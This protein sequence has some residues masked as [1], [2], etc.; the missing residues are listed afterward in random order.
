MTQP[1]CRT[2]YGSYLQTALLMKLS[3]WACMPLT[4]LNEKFNIQ[5]GVYPAA[6]VLPSLG[7]WT[8]GNG[9]HTFSVDANGI[10]IP[11]PIQ[12][13]ATD[14]ALYNHLPFVLRPIANDI[15]TAQQALYGLR[16]IEQYNGAAYVAYYL[17][18]MVLTDVIA[19]MELIN[20][21]SGVTTVTP[22]VANNSNLNPTPPVLSSSGVN[23]TTGNYAAASAQLSLLLGAADITELINVANVKY[24]D[25]NAAI[26]SEVG[27]CSGIDA[28]VSSPAVNN[29]Q[30]SFNEAIAVQIVSFINT[31]YPVQY[32]NN[33]I[34]LL[35]DVGATEPLL[36]L[37]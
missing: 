37:S 9:G 29:T 36:T 26:I 4:T 24:N 11:T 34:T 28:V 7:Y 18:R 10:A 2:L 14:A 32:S 31:F 3:N 33:A 17:R 16:R 25:P 12:H 27:L 5:S 23:L 6:G 20:V 13:I 1:I 21:A 15:T 22:F 35:L 19:A 30:I 8:I